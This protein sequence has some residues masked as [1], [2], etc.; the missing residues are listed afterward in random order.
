MKS[1]HFNMTNTSSEASWIFQ[2]RTNARS[3]QLLERQQNKQIPQP[4]VEP[5][6][7]NGFHSAQSQF[8]TGTKRSSADSSQMAALLWSLNRGISCLKM[9][10]TL[11]VSAQTLGKPWKV[12]CGSRGRPWG[13]LRAVTGPSSR[14]S[15]YNTL[16]GTPFQ[17][18]L[19]VCSFR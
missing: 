5:Y 2:G 7:S 1:V 17:I 10:D 14:A 16:R 6:A 4:T 11:P 9:T 12:P 18:T 19:S 8:I 15:R 13:E 3:Q